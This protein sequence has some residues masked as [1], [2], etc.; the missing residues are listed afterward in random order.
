MLVLLAPLLGAALGAVAR[1]WM[2]LISTD[3]EFSWSGTVFIVMAFTIAGLGH[4]IAWAARR[5][6]HRR[7]WST[8]GRTFG[9][10]LTMPLFIGAG[11]IML[12]TVVGAALCRWRS[13]WPVAMRAY[14]ALVA[15]PAPLIIVRDSWHDGMSLRMVAGLALMALTYTVIVTTLRPIAAPLDDGWRMPRPLRIALLVLAALALAAIAV[16]VAGIDGSDS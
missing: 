3:P 7:P 14:A 8:V 12:P 4:G 10:V 2:R 1:G 5:S 6:A 15:V 9:A 13:D 16:G 11:G